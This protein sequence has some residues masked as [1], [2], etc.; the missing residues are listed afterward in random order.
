MPQRSRRAPR[1][2]VV[3]D[4]AVLADVIRECLQAEGYE[5]E[6]AYDGDRALRQFYELQPDLVL[7]DMHVPPW[8]GDEILKA[9]R[10]VDAGACRFVAMTGDSVGSNEVLGT[11]VKPFD[12]RELLAVV[13]AHVDLEYAN[14][15]TA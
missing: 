8:H 11:L 15:S 6:V 14:A 2:L 10:L 3:D 9:M 12:V 1:I 13:A 4:N 7:L 5:V